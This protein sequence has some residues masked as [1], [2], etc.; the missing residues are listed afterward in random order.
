MVGFLALC[1]L[2]PV[3][4]SSAPTSPADGTY[5]A[6]APNGGIHLPFVELITPTENVFQYHNG[7][8]HHHAHAQREAAQCH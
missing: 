4:D 6:R 1:D 7:I 3:T 2:P 8:V 5:L